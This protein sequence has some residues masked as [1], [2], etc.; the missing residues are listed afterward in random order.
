VEVVNYSG[1]N[2]AGLTATAEVINLDG[3]VAWTKSAT[4]DSKEDSVATPIKLEFGAGLSAVHFV[5]LKL[6]RGATVVS[7]N[8]YWR[9]AAADDFR[10]IRTLPQVK[11]EAATKAELAGG[12]WRASTTVKNPSQAPALMVRL[13]AVG[14][15]S[16]ER[17]LPAIMSDNYL[18]LMP[19]ESRTVTF[20]VDVSDARG[21]RLAVAVDGFNVV[22]GR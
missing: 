21:E 3:K 6:A 22:S 13:K 16:G 5:R 18:I 15:K 8:T 10:A 4:L 7:E 12:V 20:E 19:G 14:E 11:L 9:G 1:G 2:A 17:L